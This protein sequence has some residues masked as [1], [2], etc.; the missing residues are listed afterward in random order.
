M[1]KKRKK[2]VT[3][4]DVTN[5]KPYRTRRF[6][7]QNHVGGVWT[8][9]TFATEDAANCYLKLCSKQNPTWQLGRHKVVPVRVTISVVR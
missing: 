4:A 5:P 7:I 6:G 8:P 1:A 2:R 3:V 9:E